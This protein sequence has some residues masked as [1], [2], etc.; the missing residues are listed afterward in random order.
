LFDHKLSVKIS[1]SWCLK[2]RKSKLS[3]FSSTWNMVCDNYPAICKWLLR[4]YNN[5]EV[6]ILTPEKGTIFNWQ[7]WSPQT[8]FLCPC[9]V[10]CF[11]YIFL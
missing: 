10:S 3:L 5:G 9:F 7:Y 6:L 2:K 11:Y 1:C 8:V 4:L